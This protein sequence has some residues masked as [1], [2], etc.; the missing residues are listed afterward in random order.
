MMNTSL[1]TQIAG[2]GVGGKEDTEGKHCYQVTGHDSVKQF[3]SHE[4]PIA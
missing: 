1:Q 3:S 2:R 4:S